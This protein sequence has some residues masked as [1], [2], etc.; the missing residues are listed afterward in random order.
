MTD[1]RI[2][3]D[4][5]D[6]DVESLRDW[7]RSEPEFRGHLRQSEAPG[8]VGAMGA[9]PE[10]IVGVISSSAATALCKAL[11][12]WLVQRRSDVRLNITGPLGRKI[13]LDVE[14]ASDAEHLLNTALGWADSDLPTPPVAD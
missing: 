7:L 2:S 10:L 4:G 13:V 5:R 1:V 3:V 11:Q 8:V 9:L 6:S 12:V 14:R